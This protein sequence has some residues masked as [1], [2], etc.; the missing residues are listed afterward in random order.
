MILI[1]LRPKPYLTAAWFQI[2]HGAFRSSMGHTHTHCP[3]IKTL[4]PSDCALTLNTHAFTLLPYNHLGSIL[5]RSATRSHPTRGCSRDSDGLNVRQ[6]LGIPYATAGR[7]TAPKLPPSRVTPF[8]ADRF[9]DSCIQMNSP[10]NVEFLKLTGGVIG[11]VTESEDC[12]SINIW[13]PS[14]FRKQ[15]TAVMVWI[16]GGGF[17]FGTVSM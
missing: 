9:G 14:I 16:Y 6:F 8:L 5:C 1:F 7:W 15:N 13:A 12:L 2:I 4:H 3:A 17:E 10:A 11:N